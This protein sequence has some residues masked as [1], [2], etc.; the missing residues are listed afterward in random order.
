[1]QNRIIQWCVLAFPAD[2]ENTMTRRASRPSGSRVRRSGSPAAKTDPLQPLQTL[3]ARRGTPRA[4]EA[5]ERWLDALGQ[6]PDAFTAAA[7]YLAAPQEGGFT[8]D[9]RWLLLSIV[10]EM[11]DHPLYGDTCADLET[12]MELE[13]KEFPDVDPDAHNDEP[14]RAASPVYRALSDAWSAL[15]TAIEVSFL[16]DI[17]MPDMAR[18]MIDDTGSWERALRDGEATLLGV[19]RIV[20][21]ADDDPFGILLP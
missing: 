19:P 1:M 10:A 7:D 16:R 9:E 20:L 17:G 14:L 21:T 2:A 3:L 11:A 8:S 13:A 6:T 12:Q 18:S 15:R 5:L 4:E